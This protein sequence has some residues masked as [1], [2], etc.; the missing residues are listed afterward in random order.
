MRGWPVGAA[1]ERGGRTR[2]EASQASMGARQLAARARGVRGVWL[3]G[4]ARVREWG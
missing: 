1:V 2:R 3:V 4:R